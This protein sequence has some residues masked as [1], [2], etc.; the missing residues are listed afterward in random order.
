MTGSL[1]TEGVGQLWRAFERSLLVNLV[2]PEDVRRSLLSRASRKADKQRVQRLDGRIHGY[3]DLVDA[4]KA[5]TPVCRSK[6]GIVII[7]NWSSQLVAKG[8]G[9]SFRHWIEK[10]DGR[11]HTVVF[12]T[13]KPL[14]SDLHAHG[15]QLFPPRKLTSLDIVSWN[16][17]AASQNSTS[18]KKASTPAGKVVGTAAANIVE[19][20]GRVFGRLKKK[21]AQQHNKTGD[22]DNQREEKKRQNN[23]HDAAVGAQTVEGI[24]N[25]EQKRGNPTDEKSKPSDAFVDQVVSVGSGDDAKELIKQWQ[26]SRMSKFKMMRVVY[27]VRWIQKKLDW[28]S[29]KKC[30]EL[31]T[32]SSIDLFD[33]DKREWVTLV[34]FAEE[35]RRWGQ[36]LSL[37]AKYDP[38][39]V[40]ES[41]AVGFELDDENT[42]CLGIHLKKVGMQPDEFAAG[43]FRASDMSR[44]FPN[45]R[46]GEEE[47]RAFLKR[48]FEKWCRGEEL[49]IRRRKKSTPS[50]ESQAVTKEALEPKVSAQFPA[51]PKDERNRPVRTLYQLLV[52]LLEPGGRKSLRQNLEC[53]DDYVE[54][55]GPLESRFCEWVYA[56]MEKRQL[57]DGLVGPILRCSDEKELRRQLGLPPKS[58][59]YS[60]PESLREVLQAIGVHEPERAPS[61]QTGESKLRAAAKFF[62]NPSWTGAIDSGAYSEAKGIQDAR[63]GLE[64]ITQIMAV[65]LWQTELQPVMRS[66]IVEGRHGFDRRG[67]KGIGGVDETE[68]S[69]RR[70]FQSLKSSTAGPLNHLLRALSKEC[71]EQEIRPSFLRGE[72]GRRELWPEMLFERIRS[73]LEPLNKL[74]HED[75]ERAAEDRKRLLDQIPKRLNLVVQAIDEDL[76][77][78]PRPVQFFRKYQDSHGIHFEGYTDDNER[79]WFYEVCQDY[80][81]RKPYLFLAATNPSAVDMTCVPLSKVLGQ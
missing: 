56:R 35:A 18:N 25:V 47:Q 38:L 2:G 34:E 43:L 1:F 20:M 72:E 13:K 77:R 41:R 40:E 80:E 46:P 15:R 62:C 36:F 69:D 61:L 11:Y 52:D 17:I 79:I 10:M 32:V 70:I 58:Q 53:I 29:D 75:L 33:T 68:P 48:Q 22:K 67:L 9:E 64:R 12:G 27:C 78:V 28:M 81:L 57:L 30:Q 8:N 50:M 49:E 31:V 5:A 14:T 26:G 76:L 42:R 4:L 37:L 51:A 59:E 16:Q 7:D 45:Y 74:I 54:L 63:K 44:L 6:G 39:V 73:L 55:K 3:G 23:R 71:V 66:V 19:G 24:N 60:W 65:F 21:R